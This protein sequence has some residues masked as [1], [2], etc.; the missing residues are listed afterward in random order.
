MKRILTFL[1][2]GTLLGAGCTKP[3]AKP[4]V[5]SSGTESPSS[6]NSGIQRVPASWNNVNISV[7]ESLTRVSF[8]GSFVITNTNSDGQVMNVDMGTAVE[9]PGERSVPGRSLRVFVVDPEDARM[10]DCAF[11]ENEWTA[12]R[13]PEMKTGLTFGTT[14]K[15]SFCES[16][17]QEGAAGNRYAV[18]TY[19]TPVD[20]QILVLEF[21]VHSVVCE[22]FERPEEQCVSFDEARDT[23]IFADILSRITVEE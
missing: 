20:G 19:S 16:K 23:A 5:P 18:Y 4:V 11:S 7:G 10:R 9:N 12:G 17:D 1:V 21:T 8:P 14:S 15:L 3:I 22:N 2:V 13:A 6:S